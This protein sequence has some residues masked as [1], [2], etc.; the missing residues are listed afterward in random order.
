MAA[1]DTAGFLVAFP[2]FASAG[3]GTLDAAVSDAILETSD[4][5]GDQYNSI[6][7]L[8]A[9]ARLADS[10]QGRAARHAAKTTNTYRDRLMRLEKAH[11]C[12][13]LRIG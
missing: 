13:N 2:E 8:R 4:T 11:A 5:W 1:P 12:A 9:A 3:S 10:P 6:V 7:Y